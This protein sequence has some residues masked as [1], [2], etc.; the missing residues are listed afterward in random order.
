MFWG[1]E[2]HWSPAVLCR[3][4]RAARG[5]VR[6]PVGL[7]AQLCGH[8]HSCARS[9]TAMGSGRMWRA[10][11]MRSR[12]IVRSVRMGGFASR[13]GA[14]EE[15]SIAAVRDLNG[16]LVASATQEGLNTPGNI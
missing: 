12:F 6:V 4:R 14:G 5:C 11:T 10:G 16:V 15:S 7:V 9:G 1:E 13:C 8:G 3:C 2:R